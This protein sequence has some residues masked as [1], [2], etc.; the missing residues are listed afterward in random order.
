MSPWL[1]C[2]DPPCSPFSNG[3]SMSLCVV[4][5]CFS[6]CKIKLEEMDRAG[7]SY[8]KMS[9]TKAFRA[10]L[11]PGVTWAEISPKIETTKVNIVAE[12]HCATRTLKNLPTTLE[13]LIGMVYGR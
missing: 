10:V 3:L 2:T 8:I 11:W 6:E 9:P 13:K 4:F 12:K 5:P 7:D 1:P